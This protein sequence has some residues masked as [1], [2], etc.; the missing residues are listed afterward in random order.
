MHVEAVKSGALTSKTGLMQDSGRVLTCHECGIQYH[1]HYDN[2]AEQLLTFY[3]ILACEVI[4]ARHP[5]HVNNI[6]L[7]LPNTRRP[8]RSQVMWSIRMD[9]GNLLKNKSGIS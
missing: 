8:A 1:L 3:S 9:L 7:E 4:T 6:V 5:H 2:E